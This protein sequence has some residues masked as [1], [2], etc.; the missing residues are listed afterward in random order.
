MQC[1]QDVSS[2]T[3][4]IQMKHLYLC[5]IQNWGALPKLKALDAAS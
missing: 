5:T 1:V 2:R 3:L 4:I